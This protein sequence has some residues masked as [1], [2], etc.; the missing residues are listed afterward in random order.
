M[1]TRRIGGD[2]GF[3][4]TVVG[5]GCNAFG[6]RIDQ[7]ATT[8][9]INGALDAGIT[10][11]DTA[12]G[13]GN[14]LS[15]EYIGNALKGRQDRVTLATKVGYNMLHVDGKGRGSS[16]NIKIAIDLSLQKL[17]TDCID[18]YQIHRPDP[19]TPIEETLGTF[20]D[21]RDE[22]KIRLFGC[23][24]FSGDQLTK[25][26]GVAAN[27]GYQGF[28]TAQNKWNVLQRG[29]EEELVPICKKNAIGVLPYYPL[30]MGLLT[31]KYI[32][33]KKA[34]EGSR[35]A[36]DDRLGSANY[37]QLETLKDFA[38]SRGYD[39]LTLAIS[40]LISQEETASVI[41]GAT[42]YE[43]LAK[44]AAGASWDMTEED[45]EKID[46]IVGFS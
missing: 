12:E 41:A 22:G 34:P 15:E 5:L 13:Y 29:I 42:R 23:S 16:E 14:G 10:F 2:D 45:L 39:L 18:L 31:G 44:N 3:E 1:K 46:E 43:Q 20:N 38:N 26:I 17:N 27:A 35:L 28:V 4:I 37:D 9:V 6:R 33:G 8:S 19:T 32:R 25:A 36:G 30:E 21:L 40:W 24:N 7:E 11:F